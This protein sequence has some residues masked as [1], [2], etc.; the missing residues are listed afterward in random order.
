MVLG[1]KKPYSSR[2]LKDPIDNEV[3]SS[4]LRDGNISLGF[5]HLASRIVRD[6]QLYGP[7]RFDAMPYAGTPLGPDG[8]IRLL[9]LE[10]GT[11]EDPVRCELSVEPIDNLPPFEAISYTWGNPE[12]RTPIVVAGETFKVT[13]NLASALR[14]LRY[15][16]RPRV[17]WVDAL[18]IDQRNTLEV[19]NQVRHMVN[20]Y[21]SATGVLAWLGPSDSSILQAFDALRTISE[22]ITPEEITALTALFQRPYWTRLWVVQEL[23]L[24]PSVLFV[25]GQEYLPWTVVDRFFHAPSG[26]G[27]A[28]FDLLPPVLR[29]TAYRL[30][31][32]WHA[33]EITH[34]GSYLTF[35]QLINKY[36]PC[37]CSETK[38]YIYS[39]LGLA[40]PST[41]IHELIYPDYTERTSTEDVFRDATA[42]AILEDQNL[43]VL[44]LVRRHSEHNVDEMSRPLPLRLSWVG[45]WS[46]VRVIR[47]LIEPDSIKQ[48]YTAYLP[49]SFTYEDNLALKD[50]GVLKI[51]GAIFDYLGI[52]Q[53]EVDPLSEGWEEGVKSWEPLDIERYQYPSGEDAV[54]AFWRTL[55]MDDCFAS[56]HKVHERLGSQQV[57]EYRDL[58]L[59]WRFGALGDKRQPDEL[60]FATCIRWGPALNT[61]AGWTFGV[62]RKGY[63]ARV[64]PDVQEGDITTLVRG[65]AVPFI[66]RSVD[67]TDYMPDAKDLVP[68]GKAWR[69]MGTAYVHGIMDG[70]A[71]TQKTLSPEQ[72]FYLV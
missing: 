1:D 36:N 12:R 29:N 28:P 50:V 42:A 38:D 55:I 2:E 17:I 56:F 4:V 51:R 9:T 53:K 15:P 20:I 43:N 6:W 48:P 32:I 49:G 37:R 47:P 3:A 59:Q 54:N 46:C 39:L 71:I 16:D 14:Y 65:S 62:T 40:R 68:A 11:P 35:S 7:L 44:C 60:S 52:V 25:S 63:F 19:N 70:E 8:Y 24:A 45:D 27:R 69:L 67:I 58:Y 34:Q 57:A 33:R 5:S 72:D 30:R 61:L 10:P 26:G 23:V 41:P 31:H 21:A 18:C 66:L 22:V 13:V 64:Q